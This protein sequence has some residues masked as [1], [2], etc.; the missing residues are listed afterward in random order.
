MSVVST[1]VC[2]ALKKSVLEW[3]GQKAIPYSQYFSWDF[4]VTEAPDLY[5]GNH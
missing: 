1:P 4:I 3:N 2:E 5:Y